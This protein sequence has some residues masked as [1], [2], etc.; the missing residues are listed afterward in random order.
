MTDLFTRFVRWLWALFGHPAAVIPMV[1]IVL[2]TGPV[3]PCII[4]VVCHIFDEAE[5]LIL[6]AMGVKAIRLSWYG[7]TGFEG[8]YP[9][10]TEWL[11]HQLVVAE[12]HGLAVTIVTQA[13]ISA[14]YI[15]TVGKK[16]R[17]QLGNEPM[18]PVS[19]AR[20]FN[21]A[22]LQYAGHLDLIPAGWASSDDLPKGYLL[23][24]SDTL[25]EAIYNGLG[26]TG[27]IC[28]HVY[29]PLGL[30][31]AV[32]NRLAIVAKAGWTGR[33]IFTEMGS[34]LV[35]AL[36]EAL[37]AA[38]GVSE[39]F[40]YALYSPATPDCPDFTLTDAQRQEIAAHA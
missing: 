26:A 2:S 4:G 36:G 38:V 32:Q 5:A 1:P 15:T 29:D 8:A 10:S 39:V 7:D 27:V 20:D 17:T 13:P 25:R 19:Y 12:A 16:A 31:A 35:G 33:V 11:G 37:T 6:V 28:L 22:C 30:T 34:H 14:A 23:C 24:T 3:M 21:A 18:D 9:G 40:L